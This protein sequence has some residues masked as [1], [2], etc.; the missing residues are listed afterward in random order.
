MKMNEMQTT[1]RET[2]MRGFTLV[3]LLV[4]IGIIGVIASLVVVGIGAAKFK[5]WESGALAQKA[6][7]E[8]AIESYKS[9]YG[10]YPP[11]DPA[12]AALRP[13][14]NPLAY[15]LGGTRR[16]APNFT[17]E[18]NPGH[19]VTPAMLTG[20][21]NLP[22]FVNAAPP[23]PKLKYSLNLSGSGSTADYVIT[24]PVPALGGAPAMFLQVPAEHPDPAVTVNVWRY[25]AYPAGGH[26][27]KTYDLWAEIKQR[28]P[29]TNFIKNWK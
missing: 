3:E 16:A 26:N 24:D 17:S 15:E 10:S 12:T 1:Q 8:L 27:P 2:R 23:G 4:V 21:F 7:L 5:K 19:V 13:D 18:S 11:D 22:G 20:Y 29:G 28:A 9:A 14:R 6:K 25:R